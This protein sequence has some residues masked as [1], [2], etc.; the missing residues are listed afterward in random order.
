MRTLTIILGILA[1][2][3]PAGLADDAAQLDALRKKI[4]GTWKHQHRQIGVQAD[5]LKK[6]GADGSYSARSHVRMLGKNASVDYEGTWEILPGPI[7]RLKV[8]KSSNRLFVPKDA[9]YTM[10]NLEIEGDVMTYSH[11]GKDNREVRQ[12]G[13]IETD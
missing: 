13:Q 3:L 4:A 7:L 2:A 1:L 11:D 8:S 6:Y 9:I 12:E 5:T 10:E